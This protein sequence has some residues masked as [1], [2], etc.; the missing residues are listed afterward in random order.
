MS[1]DL[2]HIV[3]DKVHFLFHFGNDLITDQSF[4]NFLDFFNLLLSWKCPLDF[5]VKVEESACL[6]A[7]DQVVVVHDVLV[8]LFL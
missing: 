7:G 6:Y 4:D 1:Q 8:K 3:T 5:Q 2:F